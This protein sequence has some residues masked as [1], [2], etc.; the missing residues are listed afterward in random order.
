MKSQSVKQTIAIH[1]LP[2]ISRIK[3]NQTMKFGQLIEYDMRNTFLEKSYTKCGRETVPRS[4]SK[5]PIL[6]ISLDHQSKFLHRWFS[7]CDKMR[8][9]EIY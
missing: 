4:F 9:I 1:L 5:R 8:A 6:S 2:N 3:E 7:L